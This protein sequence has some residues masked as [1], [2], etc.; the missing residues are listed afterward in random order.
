[1]IWCVIDSM[2]CLRTKLT[3]LVLVFLFM[4]NVESIPLDW[5]RVQRVA[6]ILN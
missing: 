4:T 1:M 3:E 5:K 2:S 6:L